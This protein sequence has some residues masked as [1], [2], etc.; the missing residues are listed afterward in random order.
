PR[1]L[2]FG[3]LARGA[4]GPSLRAELVDL[5]LATGALDFHLHEPPL[6]D[7]GAPRP[8]ACS[9]ARWHAVHGGPLTNRWH[10]EVHL[11]DAPMRSVLG[12]LDGTRTLADVARAAGCTDA[13]AGAC[14]EAIARAALLVG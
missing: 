10:Q 12:L 11:E 7:A 2:P 9:V 8:L 5:W 4:D 13:V 3:D 14:V 1:S 6:A